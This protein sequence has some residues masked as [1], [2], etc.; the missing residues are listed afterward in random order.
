MGQW[1]S[2]VGPPQLPR[3]CGPARRK[4]SSHRPMS[5]ASFELEFEYRA[6]PFRVWV[7][8]ETEKGQVAHMRGT[9]GIMPFTGDGASLRQDMLAVMDFANRFLPLEL[10]ASGGREITLHSR[11]E[12][13]T[14][15]TPAAV[16]AAA[17]ERLAQ[18]KRVLDLVNALQPAHRSQASEDPSSKAA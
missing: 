12:V 2:G 18:A 15:L 6:M 9:I 8:A 7:D 13:A 11:L 14:T 1:N 5:Q 4:D 10:S 17:I 16:L 3:T